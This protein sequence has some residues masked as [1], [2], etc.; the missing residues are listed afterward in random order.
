MGVPLGRR[1]WL[2]GDSQKTRRIAGVVC[3]GTNMPQGRKRGKNVIL[4]R[5]S[6]FE[7]RIDLVNH[8]VFR[9]DAF[10]YFNKRNPWLHRL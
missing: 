1:D 9:A 2:E 8:H 10:F 5:I 7:Y 6:I 3:D 4:G